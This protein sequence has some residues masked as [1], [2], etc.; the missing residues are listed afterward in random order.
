MATVHKLQLQGAGLG[1]GDQVR[2]PKLEPTFLPKYLICVL[3]QAERETFRNITNHPFAVTAA[4]RT[5]CE[6]KHRE[7]VGTSLTVYSFCAGSAYLKLRELA[8]KALDIFITAVQ[9]RSREP[10]G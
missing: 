3:F 1:S 5:C 2:K 10:L 4:V 8:L 9:I 7:R 6:V